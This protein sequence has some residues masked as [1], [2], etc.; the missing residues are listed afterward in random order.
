[1]AS[2]LIGDGQPLVPP[3]LPAFTLG[4][5]LP[6]DEHTA[7]FNQLAAD[8]AQSSYTDVSPPSLELEMSGPDFAVWN[9][10]VE[11]SD[12]VLHAEF[13]SKAPTDD[14]V[15]AIEFRSVDSVS[16]YLWISSDATFSTFDVEGTLDRTP[17]SIDL[18]VVGEDGYVALD[19][20]LLAVLDLADWLVAGDIVFAAVSADQPAGSTT[21]LSV[22]RLSILDIKGGISFLHLPPLT[23]PTL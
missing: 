23:S 2:L 6:D 9:A 16:Q 20:Q 22:E 21:T 8:I 18:I 14:W 3:G 11:I 15:F 13:A 5:D 7:T 4:A 17:S 12:F 10:G 19:G 1:Q